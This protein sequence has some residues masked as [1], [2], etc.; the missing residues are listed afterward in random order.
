MIDLPTHS[1]V[2]DFLPVP[3]V[4]TIPIML[5]FADLYQL[6]CSLKIHL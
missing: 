5:T 3:Y 4:M 6:F 1:E 2:I